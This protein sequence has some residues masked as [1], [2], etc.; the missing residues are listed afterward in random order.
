MGSGKETR[1]SEGCGGD[2]ESGAMVGRCDSGE[3]QVHR[4]QCVRAKASQKI[5]RP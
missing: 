2:D 4:L 3:K 5:F 1:G